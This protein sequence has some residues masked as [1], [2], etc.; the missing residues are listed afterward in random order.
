[1]SIPS[2]CIELEEAERLAG[3]VAKLNPEFCEN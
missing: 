3:K 1:M 2:A